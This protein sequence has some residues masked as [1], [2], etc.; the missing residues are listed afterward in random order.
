MHVFLVYTL[1]MP[2]STALSFNDSDCQVTYYLTFVS[3]H[4]SLV[5]IPFDILTIIV[6]TVSYMNLDSSSTGYMLVN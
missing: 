3:C 6:N 5:L 1:D 4:Y 2:R